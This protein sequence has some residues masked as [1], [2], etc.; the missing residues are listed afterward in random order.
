MLRHPRA[1]LTY[2]DSIDR[3][4]LLDVRHRLTI[5]AIA[6]SSGDG[7]VILA[8]LDD[9]IANYVRALIGERETRD[10]LFP[11]SGNREIP[12][13][14]QRLAQTRYEARLRQ[15]QADL[16]AARQADD[17]PAILAGLELMNKLAARK[18]A[19]A[20]RESPY[21]RDTRSPVG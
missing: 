8:S 15:V 14:I 6:S 7:D 10:E 20:P 4:D 19:F 12:I 21:F 13:A 2:L 1:A 18:Q 17:E 9:E 16:Q 5:D 11:S 3:E